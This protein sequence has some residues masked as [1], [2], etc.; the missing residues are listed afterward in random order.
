MQTTNIGALV[1]AQADNDPHAESIAIVAAVDRKVSRRDPTLLV[2]FL[3]RVAFG[4]TECW[5]WV[6]PRTDLGYGR[7][8]NARNYGVHEIA[9]H[10][11]SWTLFRGAVPA[12]LSVLHRCDVRACVNPDHLFLGTQADN[13]L[14]MARKGRGRTTPRY[15]ESNPCARLSAAD[16]D[17][18]RSA[19]AAGE[20]QI[21][22][23]RRYGVGAMTISRVIRRHTWRY[24]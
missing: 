14:D 20:T 7:M 1:N 18:I 2:A 16:V 10:R 8:T 12:G 3:R 11:V 23:A 15:G 22:L 13:V 21:A 6:G 17:A 5:H 24:Q 9:A 19:H 4:L